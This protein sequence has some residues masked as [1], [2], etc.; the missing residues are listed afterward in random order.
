MELLFPVVP[1]VLHI[2]VIFH[3]LD[4]LFHQL[5]VLFALQLLIV[6]GNHFDLCGD[7]GV[8]NRRIPNFLTDF[9]IVP[10]LSEILTKI[11][12]FANIFHN[13]A[14]TYIIAYG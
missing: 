8:E 11:N 1:D 12:R 5:H 6:L 9:V 13:S 14:T 3:D 4:E 7:E 2:V 10:E